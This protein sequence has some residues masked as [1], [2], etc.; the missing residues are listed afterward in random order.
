MACLYGYK[1][2][3]GG[4]GFDQNRETDQSAEKMFVWDVLFQAELI[5]QCVLLS[6]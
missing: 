6:R 3:Q 4:H 2:G 5:K 1:R